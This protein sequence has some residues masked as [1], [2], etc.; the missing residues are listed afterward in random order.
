[1]RLVVIESPYAGNVRDNVAYAKRCM[2]DSLMR[3][4]APFAS[5][6]LY[7]E[8]LD[9]RVPA[10]RE[11]G[12]RAG[13]AW[14]EEAK[15]VVFYVDRGI[16]YGMIRGYVR[17]LRRPHCSVELRALD[18]QV[19]PTDWALLTEQP[20]SLFSAQK[21]EEVPSAPGPLE[22]PGTLPPSGAE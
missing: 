11:L 3:G 8:V 12:M 9:D 7:T 13:F 22:T 1:M 14:G 17:A 18:R 21:A 5:H 20:V 19:L 6:L 16:S 2:F 4:E 10:E 15:A